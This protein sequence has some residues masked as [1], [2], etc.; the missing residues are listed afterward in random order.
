MDQ[1]C[2]ILSNSHIIALSNHIFLRLQFN[3]TTNQ[4]VVGKLGSH[5]ETFSSK[6]ISYLEKQLSNPTLHCKLKKYIFF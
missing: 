4:H 6:R 1:R 5:V 2:G 3:K